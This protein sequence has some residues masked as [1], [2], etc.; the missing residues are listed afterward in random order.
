[1]IGTLAERRIRVLPPLLVNQ[2]AAGEVVERPAS[3]VKELVENSLDAGATRIAVELE[4]GGIELIRVSDD[5]CGM[6]AD[7]LPLALAAHATSKIAEPDDLTRIAT[8]GFRGEALASI[9]SVARVVIR[10]RP[11]GADAA[12]EMD[13]EGDRVSPVR[14]AAGAR[15]TAVSVRNLFFNTPAR[16][17][18]LRT[19][20]TEQGRSVDSVRDLATAHPGVGFTMVC[21]GRTVLEVPPDQSPRER[22]LAVLG[23]ELADQ[24]L[25]VRADRFDAFGGGIGGVALWGLA[26]L[27]SIARATNQAQHVFLNGRVVRDKTIQHAIKE[28]YRGLIEPGRHPTIVL[29]IEIDPTAVDVNVHPA[30]AEVRFRDPSLIHSAVLRAVRETLR[31]A[32]LTPTFATAMPGARAGEGRAILPAAPIN[33]G[34]VSPEA[35][36][37]DVS[38]FVDYFKRVTPGPS[39][40]PLGYEAIRE[41]VD[42]VAGGPARGPETG[43]PGSEDGPEAHSTSAGEPAPLSAPRPASRVLQVHNS[44]LL[45]QDEHGVV[46]IDQ[47][48]LHERVM[49]EALVARVAAGPLE[50]QRL[51][52]PAI[53]PAS[54]ARVERLTDLAPL[55]GRIGVEAEPIGPTSVAVHAFPSFLFDRGV[56]PVEFLED[57]FER[58]E[59][60]G[61]APGSEQALHEVLDMM[62]CKA[63]VKAGDRMSDP[64]L[65]ELV[66]LREAVERSS[67]CPH[68]RPT[69][70]RLTI[71]ELERLFG[72]S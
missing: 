16:R 66:T 41:A 72:R 36:A 71:R 65:A 15:G 45:T 58:S 9:A 17:K 23:V 27:P 70:I 14:P 2:I 56:D 48:A 21:D 47:H 63:A 25:E 59:A 7:Q 22:A 57:L 30:K 28:A 51:L 61:F 62:S 60:E 42:P 43:R 53:V 26:G 49:F 29:M 37:R 67:N 13:A 18:F 55:L 69:S 35:R 32:D 10:S 40:S 44:F 64:E 39:L 11:E 46:I 8:L 1:M 4:Q 12:A 34:V 68:G 52:S 5:G 54:P 24:L 31:A 20:P 6:E 33:S 38:A 3:V 50:S 19:P